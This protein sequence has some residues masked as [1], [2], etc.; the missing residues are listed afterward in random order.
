MRRNLTSWA[1]PTATFAVLCVFV[2]MW[3]DRV[4]MSDSW[5]IGRFL[6]LHDR[7]QLGVGDFWKPFNG[8]RILLPRLVLYGLARATHWN[9]AFEV[10]TSLAIAFATFLLLVHLIRFS[11]AD[12]RHQ[13]IAMAATS[14]VMFSPLAWENWVWGWDIEWFLANF[15][16]VLALAALTAMPGL[17]HRDRFALAVCGGLVAT[18]SLA[19]GTLMWFACAPVFFIRRDWRRYAYVWIGCSI[20]ML[21]IY[22]IGYDGAN[23]SGAVLETPRRFAGFA[24]NFVLRPLSYQ[25]R[26]PV[27]AFVVLVAAFIAVVRVA[28]REPGR[29]SNESL[30]WLV[31]VA[32]GVLTAFLTAVA[33]ARV[34]GATQANQSRYTTA[35]SLVVIGVLMLLTRTLERAPTNSI[36]ASAIAVM[37]AVM[38]LVGVNYVGGIKSMEVHYHGAMQRTR[39]CVEAARTVHDPCVSAT[40]LQPMW[41]YVEYVRRHHL[42]GL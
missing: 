6:S 29:V 27:L 40:H 23:D 21:G 42:A 32:F 15:G 31:M 20:V 14:I 4:P 7:G 24:V 1:I 17:N 18:L 8:H 41:R 38:V 39:R 3:R 37:L 2:G 9:L 10:A 36:R 13:A 12:A 11:I 16:F 28:T 22:A 30:P 35:A 26:F 33:R 5:D 34:L 19:N 25:G